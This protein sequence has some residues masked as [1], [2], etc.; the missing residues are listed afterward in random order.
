MQEIID[1]YLTRHGDFEEEYLQESLDIGKYLVKKPKT[2]FFMRVVGES[3]INAG[4]NSG[5]L[6]VI[7]RAE[8][9]RDK[10]VVVARI[11]SEFTVKQLRIEA[12]KYW[13][14]PANDNYDAI[15]I[16]EGE[17]FE[18]FGVVTH[19]ITDIKKK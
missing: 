8:Q 17:D 12:G 1:D 19:A 6:L 5:D 3:T 18:I 14:Y 4:I 10:S 7:D 11:G 2:T 9:A 13:L 16:N 15:E